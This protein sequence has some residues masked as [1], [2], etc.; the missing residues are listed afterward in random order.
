[1]LLLQNRVYETHQ[2]FPLLFANRAH[3]HYIRNRVESKLYR[4]Q[5]LFTP[6]DDHHAN[7]LHAI[8]L[9]ATEHD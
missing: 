2:I 4:K 3:G 7:E 8:E 5:F 6:V 1:M 9:N